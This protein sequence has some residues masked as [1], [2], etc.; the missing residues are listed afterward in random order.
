[1]Q[2]EVTTPV[3]TSIVIDRIT[4]KLTFIILWQL[5]AEEISGKGINDILYEIVMP[6]QSKHYQQL[7]RSLPETTKE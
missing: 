3:V 5:S 4:L 7:K 6:L 1:L 2:V